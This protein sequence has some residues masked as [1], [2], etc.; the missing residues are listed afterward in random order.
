LLE[1][2]LK[3]LPELTSWFCNAMQFLHSSQCHAVRDEFR[4]A[5]HFVHSSRGD[6]KRL[7]SWKLSSMY[8]FARALPM[9]FVPTQKR[10]NR[11]VGRKRKSLGKVLHVL[12]PSH[13]LKPVK[14]KGSW[15]CDGCTPDAQ[16]FPL[17]RRDRRF[18]CARCDFDLCYECFTI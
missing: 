4:N 3:V 11:G 5:M 17:S 13:K 8:Q 1:W 9:M 6:I 12:H 18:R 14:L 2:D 7:M 16:E 10:K 15:A